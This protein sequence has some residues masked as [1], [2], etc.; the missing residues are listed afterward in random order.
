[1][2][3]PDAHGTIECMSRTELSPAGV[4]ERAVAAAQRAAD[5]AGVEVRSLETV[6]EFEAASRLISEIWSDDEPK[7][8]AGLL[9]ALS[10]AGNFVAG[11]WRAGELVGISFGFFG[12]EDG[13]LHLHS[14]ITGVHPALQGQ[15]VGFALKQFQRT[16][17]LERGARTIQWTADPLVRRNMFFNLMKLGTT[18]VAYHDDFYGRIADGLNASEETDRVVVRWDLASERAAAAADGVPATRP[19]TDGRVILGAGVDGE[20]AISGGDGD[21]LLAWIPE[22]IVLLREAD[23]AAAHAWRRALRDTAGRCLDNGFRAD[24]I[25]RD[26]WFVLTR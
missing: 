5:Q 9:R 17:T 10:H 26:G 19:A 6:P 20:P 16:W 23:P 4:V 12:L 8:P 24:A 1:M 7:A 3:P 25:T 11:A 2:P 15:S 13:E 22:D 18:I 21:T 14:H